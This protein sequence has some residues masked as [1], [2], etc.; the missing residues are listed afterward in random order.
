[1]SQDQNIGG[2]NAGG[3]GAGRDAAGEKGLTSTSKAE[4][5]R[6]S[7]GMTE[8]PKPCSTMAR[9]EKSSFRA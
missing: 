3:Q 8:T 5:R 2:Q 1:M 6:I 9:A 4:L 7:S